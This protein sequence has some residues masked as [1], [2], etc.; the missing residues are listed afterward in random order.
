MKGAPEK[1]NGIDH[2]SAVFQIGFKNL[3]GKHGRRGTNYQER[4]FY[5][6]FTL[7]SLPREGFL[8]GFYPTELTFWSLPGHFFST[9][10][11]FMGRVATTPYQRIP[12]GRSCGYHTY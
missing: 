8:P 10:L 7:Q 1:L 2:R 11:F 3:T 12:H 9:L 5:L 6:P 4:A